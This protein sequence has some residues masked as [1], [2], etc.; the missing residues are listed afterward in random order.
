ME[1]SNIKSAKAPRTPLQVILPKNER[2]EGRLSLP[3]T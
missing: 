3:I 2:R 1:I